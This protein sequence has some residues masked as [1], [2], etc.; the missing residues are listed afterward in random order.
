MFGKFFHNERKSVDNGDRYSSK[1]ALLL[2]SSSTSKN[3]STNPN[4]AFQKLFTA[5]ENKTSKD[6]TFDQLANYI[7]VI[8]EADCLDQKN[9]N[10]MT[11]LYEAIYREHFDMFALLIEAGA[12]PFTFINPNMQSAVTLLLIKAT[13]KPDTYTPYLA[14]VV[15]HYGESFWDNCTKA[16][17]TTEHK[18]NHIS[19]LKLAESV[20][21]KFDFKE[22]QQRVNNHLIQLNVSHAAETDV[23][24][25]PC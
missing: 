21:T 22:I 13:D 2:L 17:S 15:K 10:G 18:G 11:L 12:D 1:E 25:S 20:R 9:K 3:K 24:I 16:T 5:L 6:M 8:K 19:S 7:Q 23:T 14:C 4:Q